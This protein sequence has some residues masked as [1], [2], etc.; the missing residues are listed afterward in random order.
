MYRW[1]WLVLCSLG[2]HPGQ[3]RQRLHHSGGLRKESGALSS[4]AAEIMSLETCRDE[5]ASGLV[6]LSCIKCYIITYNL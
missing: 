6:A 3:L 1:Q 4:H 2:K 5:V